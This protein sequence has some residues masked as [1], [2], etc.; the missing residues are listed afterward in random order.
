[1][2][3][4]NISFYLKIILFKDTVILIFSFCY[5][6]SETIESTL[7][8]IVIYNVNIIFFDRIGIMIIL[9]NRYIDLSDYLYT[10][11]CLLYVNTLF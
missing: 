7:A 11:I 8:N 4:E 1:M 3:C 9:K 2:I 6:F 5:I 10:K